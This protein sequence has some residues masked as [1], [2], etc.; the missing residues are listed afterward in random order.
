MPDFAIFF[1]FGC[2]LIC[3]PAKELTYLPDKAYL[4]M[5]FLFAQVGYVSSQ[6]GISI[7]GYV[8][9][10]QGTAQAGDRRSWRKGAGSIQA[11]QAVIGSG[12]RRV[13]DAGREDGTST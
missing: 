1:F 8:Q 7:L 11:I 3:I 5:I 2:D 12:L 13:V 4:K 6:E 9:V 10:C